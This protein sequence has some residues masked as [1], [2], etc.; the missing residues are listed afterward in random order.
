MVA[1]SPARATVNYNNVLGNVGYNIGASSEDATPN[2]G[3]DVL[4][5]IG[6]VLNIALG[7]LGVVLLLLSIYAGFLWMTAGGNEEQVAKAKTLLR[8]AIIGL[9]ITLSAYSISY[10]VTSQ[11]GSAVSGETSSVSE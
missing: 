2:T 4:S 1:I 9:I 10:F 5:V 3:T 11:V 8:N 7:L 6:N